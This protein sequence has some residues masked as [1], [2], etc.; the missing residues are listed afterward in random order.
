MNLQTVFINCLY[1][2][3]ATIVVYFI[4]GL[5][6]QLWNDFKSW[7]KK[8]EAEKKLKASFSKLLELVEKERK[9]NEE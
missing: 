3:G 2:L 4:V 8:R 1:L 6:L 5:W 9:E 7:K